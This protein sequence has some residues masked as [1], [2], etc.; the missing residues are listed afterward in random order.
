VPI[1]KA[2]TPAS[3]ADA[4]SWAAG[5]LPAEGRGLSGPAILT[6]DDRS[7]EAAALLDL[8]GVHACVLAPL[9]DAEGS[10]RGFLAADH[11]PN[12]SLP[13]PGDER[14]LSIIADQ[15]S[16][17]LRYE[18]MSREQAR[19]A[20]V[21]PLTGAATR[22]RLMDRLDHLISLSGRT[23]I[24]L[25]L[26]I[27]DLDHFKKFN[28]TMG[29]QVGDRLL[30]ELVGVLTEHVRKTDLV[31]R[32]GG[33]EFVVLFPGA[34]LAGAHVVAES[35]RHEIFE[36][37]RAHAAAY[38]HLPI[39]VSVGVAQLRVGEHGDVLEDAQALIGRA[40][41]VLY[42]AKHNGRNRVERAA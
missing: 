4:R 7:P 3:V 42:Q 6:R 11:G 41:E 36:F 33:E 21:D 1:P 5:T 22:R 10:T 17:L 35:L 2:F 8:L 15:A 31:G 28:D 14:C 39:S 19:M 26:A 32:Y 25:S 20:T 37:G 9:S 24:P 13:L 27:L 23:R 29:H 30:Q 18:R 34:D 12:G 16:L 40:D 38:D